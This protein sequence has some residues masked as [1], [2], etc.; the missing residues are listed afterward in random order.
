VRWIT[1]AGGTA[2]IAHPARYRFTPTEE[3]ALITEFVAHGGRGI[4]VVTG[5]H[6]VAEQV[7]YANVALEFGLL[8]SRGSDFHSPGE[9]HTEL[10][11]LPDLPGRLTPVWSALRTGRAHA[12]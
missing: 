5:S 10:G 1:G 2:V 11:A 9:S 12:H 3:Y 7:T 8:A 4:E 6:T